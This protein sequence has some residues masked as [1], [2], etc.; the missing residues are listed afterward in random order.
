MKKIFISVFFF[1][2]PA[3][4]VFCQDALTISPN[5]NVGIG[6]NSP[7]EALEVIG[8]IRAAGRITDRTGF[9]T[10][11]G[12]ILM[13]PLDT[14]PR[15]WIECNGASVSRFTY[16]DL[17]ETIGTKYGA[18]DG[19][20]TFKLPDLRGMFSRGWCYEKV[21]NFDREGSNAVE[22]RPENIGMMFIIKY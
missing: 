17:F 8:D 18:G 2:S 21:E 12:S 5:G 6:T 20:T 9:V 4:F 22:T 13:W 19:S 14:P 3:L 15:G 10:P 16:A 11:V 1:F 7:S